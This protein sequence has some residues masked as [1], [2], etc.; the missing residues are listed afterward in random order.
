MPIFTPLMGR[1]I[2]KDVP[3]GKI[4]LTHSEVTALTN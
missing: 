4:T 3:A 1:N 2:R